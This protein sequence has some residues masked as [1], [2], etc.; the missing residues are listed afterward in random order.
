MILVYKHIPNDNARDEHRKQ[1]AS[2]RLLELYSWNQSS[3]L[4]C[5]IPADTVNIRHVISQIRTFLGP[6]CFRLESKLSVV[7]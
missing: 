3:Q 4:L 7:G 5:C 1:C 2:K 6:R